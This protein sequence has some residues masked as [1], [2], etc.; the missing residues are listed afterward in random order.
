MTEAPATTVRRLARSTPTAALGTLDADGAPYVSL[1]LVAVDHDASPILLLSDLAD[2]TKHFKR[3]PRVSLLIDGT[4]G[5]ASPL[6][7]ARATLTGEIV[8]ASASHQ[9]ARFLARHP[10][11]TGYAGFADFNFYRL[12][13]QR[14]HLVAGFGRIHWVEGA[15][16]LLPVDDQLPLVAAEPGILEHMNA[17]HADAV[18][19]YATR[20]LGRPD[21][22]WQM[23]G[24][25]PEGAD[26]RLD[27]SVARLWFDQPVR[28]AA[29]ARATLV[30]LV[31]RARQV[32]RVT[33][34]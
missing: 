6:A 21:G 27:G 28:D 26:L 1:V 11:A 23:T 20:L 25:D 33:D 3:D 19:L 2:H 15:E 30:A 4:M 22:A 17:D 24:I 13:L 34:H 9:S 29:S 8:A 16:V 10:D 12:N 5:M 18:A 31:R 32:D 7:G 14:A